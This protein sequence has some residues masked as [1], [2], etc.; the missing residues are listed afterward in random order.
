[1]LVTKMGT[2]TGPR[3]ATPT[4]PE[5]L[6]LTPSI[7]LE[8]VSTSSTYTPGAKYSGMVF[9]LEKLVSRASPLPG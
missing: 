5:V 6:V 2:F 8:P 4:I 3:S 1:M 9:L 7:G